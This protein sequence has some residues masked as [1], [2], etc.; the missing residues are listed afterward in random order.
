MNDKRIALIGILLLTLLAALVRIPF[1]GHES[2]WKDELSI[3]SFVNVPTLSQAIYNGAI[4][5]PHPPLYM[6]IVFPIVHLLGMSEAAFRLP[7]ALIG[8]ASVPLIYIL[9]SRAFSWREGLIAAAFMALMFRPIYYSLE[10]RNYML[11]GAASITLG[12]AWVTVAKAT[13]ERQR[14]SL[15]SLAGYAILVALAP[16]SHYFGVLLAVVMFAHLGWR[17]RSLNSGRKNVATLMGITALLYLPWL[18]FAAKTFGRSNNA[19]WIS[20]PHL[21]APVVFFTFFYGKSPILVFL[22]TTIAVGYLIFAGQRKTGNSDIVKENPT[23]SREVALLLVVWLAGPFF[24]TLIKSLLSTSFFLNRY[25][26]ICLPAA[27]LCTARGITLMSDLRKSPI[28]APAI[29]SLIIV[30]AW[31]QMVILQHM[32]TKSARSEYRE[33]VQYVERNLAA[34]NGKVIPV[35]STQPMLSYYVDQPN[36]GLILA[37]ADHID[38]NLPS[39]KTYLELNHPTEFWFLDA[40]DDNL[41]AGRQFFNPVG[42][43][44]EKYRKFKDIVA[45]HYIKSNP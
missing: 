23:W 13:V 1:L 10:A 41:L 18:P 36:S 31:T 12:I 6:V 17:S 14:L 3:W 35:L 7:S 22:M 34:K 44:Q 19:F 32:F 37:A 27:Y 39:T 33:A 26:F 11:L 42:Y 29:T 30:M 38:T 28:L 8:I 5:D 15:K 25:F 40:R 16:Y 45:I 4:V 2:F 43:S 20:K 21:D 9:A 24:I